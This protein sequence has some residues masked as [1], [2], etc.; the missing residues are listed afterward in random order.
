MTEEKVIPVTKQE[1][2]WVVITWWDMES[3]IIRSIVPLVD[4]ERISEEVELSGG[5][6]ISK[7]NIDKLSKNEKLIEEHKEEYAPLTKEGITV[8]TEMP[9]DEEYEKEQERIEER[10][11]NFANR[12]VNSG[13][14]PCNSQM[15]EE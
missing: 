8:D 2:G 12:R 13:E 5:K 15:D 10:K 3:N 9:D 6:V 11:I 1:Y 4:E 14:T 7:R